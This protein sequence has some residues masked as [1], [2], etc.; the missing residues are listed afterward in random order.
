M[1][2]GVAL[3]LFA[4]GAILA[5]AVRITTPVINLQIAGWVLMA[6]SVIGAYLSR[7]NPMWVRK[8]IVVPRRRRLARIREVDQAV[9]PP[10][11]K[12][13]PHAIVSDIDVVEPGD[14]TI[15]KMVAEHL[16]EEK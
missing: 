16:A 13:N 14:T 15:E 1:E 3:L 10:Y 5:F 9:Y 8:V 7:R 11:V 2:M 6:I 12:E 4:L